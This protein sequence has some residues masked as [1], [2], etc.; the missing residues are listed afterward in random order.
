MVKLLRLVVLV[1]GVSVGCAS[2]PPLATVPHVDLPRFMGDWYV[3]ANIPTWVEKGAHNA[4]ESYALA[5]DGTIA[6]TFTF[7]D[8]AFDGPEKRYTP[9]GTVVDTATN[10]TWDMQFV[11][12][13]QAEYLI[14]YL[15]DGYTRTIIGRSARDY[16]WLMAR[17]PTIADAEYAELLKRIGDMGYDVSKVEKVPQ[18]W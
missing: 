10:S 7:R 16:V 1:L 4:V 15:D 12:P 13:I 3:I 18:R 6:T 17:T 14:V 5:P 2:Q 11:W 8:G 9:V